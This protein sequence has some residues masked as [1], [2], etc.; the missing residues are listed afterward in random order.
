MTGA[1]CTQFCLKTEA[2]HAKAT[3]VSLCKA[4][5]ISRR[6]IIVTNKLDAPILVSWDDIR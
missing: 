6:L 1:G 5:S 2:F 4:T 3:Q